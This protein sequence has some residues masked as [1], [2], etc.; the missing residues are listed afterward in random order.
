M[1]NGSLAARARAWGITAAFRDAQGQSRRTS[2]ET[3]Q[4]LLAAMGADGPQPSTEDYP[5]VVRGGRSH[6][7][8]APAQVTTEDGRVLFAEPRIPADLPCGY[9]MLHT[10]DDKQRRLIVVP[11]TCHPAPVQPSW[12]FALQLYALR[13]RRSWGMGDLE[14]LREFS[15]WL[16]PLGGRLLLINPLHAVSPGLPQQASPYF[17]SSRLYRN[18]LYL[19][20][21]KV[22]GADLAGKE[23]AELRRSAT[24]LNK[25]R[26]IDRDAVYRSKLAALERIFERGADDGRFSD[27]RRR[28]GAYLHDFA[29]FCALTERYSPDWRRWP[30]GFRRPGT[31]AVRR[32]A[33]TNERRVRFHEWLQWLLDEQ[34]KQAASAGGLIGDLAVGVDPQG[35][36]AWLFQDQL[37]SGIHVGAPPDAFQP[38]GQDWGLPPFDPHR[39]RAAGYEPLTRILRATF[40]HVSGIRLDH[41]MALFRLYWI[42]P[43][44]PAAHGAYVRYPADDL[45]GILAL[46]SRRAS[47]Y[48]IGEDLG[49]VEP[50]VR[51]ELRRR[52]I[53]PYR[54]F[55]FES[56]SPRQYP[57]AAVA[58]ATTHDLP[59][60]AGT[61]TGADHALRRGLGLTENEDDPLRRRLSRFTRLPRSEPP[62]KVIERVYLALSRSPA[63]LLAITIEDALGVEER[64]N[65][66]GTDETLPNWRLAL[67]APLEA[68]RADAGVRR[69]IGIVRRA[70][71]DRISP[72]DA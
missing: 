69:L 7:L 62:S 5:L 43:G 66:P 13:S 19:R 1:S 3:M 39:L 54:V 14:D 46:E 63:R 17:P 6:S 57:R 49:T 16:S 50:G 67:Q 68:I 37:A 12:G 41:V 22:P 71:P 36:D 4:A 60:L 34:L 72:G 11:A 53:L 10:R 33:K 59:T 65:L 70:R 35:A 26:L 24:A 38:A 23:I 8:A 2:A 55:W 48:V 31:T 61:W 30:E 21:E 32:F 18:P 9:H 20:I 64:P 52:N 47:A 45:L 56:R 42:P 29:T 51:A 15:R 25:E 58:A 27:Y 28:E 40:A 44:I